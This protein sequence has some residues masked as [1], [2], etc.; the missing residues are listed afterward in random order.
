MALPM[1]ISMMEMSKLN[2]PY[3]NKAKT[4]K[5]VELGMSCGLAR[6][7]QILKNKFNK[8]S[9]IRI[10]ASISLNGTYFRYKNFNLQ[11]LF[12]KLY[13]LGKFKLTHA[14]NR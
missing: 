7:R 12:W 14:L 4:I 2:K 11:C 9:I 6:R 13:N 5:K 8:T 10:D 1:G 3:D